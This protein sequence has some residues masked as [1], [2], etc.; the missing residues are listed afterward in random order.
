MLSKLTPTQTFA[1]LN[2]G[3]LPAIACVVI[4]S[5]TAAHRVTAGT[6]EAW[7]ACC[8]PCLIGCWRPRMSAAAGFGPSCP[9]RI[10]CTLGRRGL[11]AA[12]L[13]SG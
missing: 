5:A 10:K 2:V 12:V 4:I 11:I 7:S 13:R 6:P 3:L 8:L 9:S 1:A